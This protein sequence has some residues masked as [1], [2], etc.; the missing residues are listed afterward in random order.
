MLTIALRGVTAAV[1]LVL[2]LTPPA[3]ADSARQIGPLPLAEAVD[4]LPS[5]AES[6]DGY[7]RT[8][9]KHWNTGQDPSDGCNTRVICTLK[10]G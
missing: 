9:F 10:S 1:F 6:R 4:R 8:S 2:P 5:A 3:A 7:Q